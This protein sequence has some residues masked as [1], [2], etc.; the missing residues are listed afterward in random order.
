MKEIFEVGAGSV[1]GRDHLRVLGERNN[2]DSFA[3]MFGDGILVA[4]VTDGCGSEKN[5][6]VGAKIGAR[7]L[8]DLLQPGWESLTKEASGKVLKKSY[9][10]ISY[11]LA[12]VAKDFLAKL[13]IF[14]AGSNFVDTIREE[15]L[16][17]TLGVVA[18]PCWIAV[19]S[20]G[21]G[22]FA[23]NSQVTILDSGP[24]NQP[25]Y[26]VY[27][28]F[29]A[30]LVRPA[31]YPFKIRAIQK[32]NKVNSILIGTDGLNDL[33]TAEEKALPGKQELVG[34]LSQFW[35]EDQFFANPD[36]VRRRLALINREVIQGDWKNQRI[37][38]ENG[39]LHDDT[40]L[41]VVR[42][43]EGIDGSTA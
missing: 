23:I 39:L 36:S 13:E 2:Q 21:D 22:V 17:T 7:L 3:Y 10:G 16:F 33:I 11:L 25:D 4:V 5:S 8:V 15:F 6:E 12:K 40:T 18:T 9:L 19:F 27:A 24:D 26:P 35:V 34:P 14:A 29:N 41:I 1:I 37:I 30:P 43:K 32:T 20:A 31:Y 38:R 28:L 42:R